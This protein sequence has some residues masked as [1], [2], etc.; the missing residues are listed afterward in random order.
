MAN[1]RVGT[2]PGAG[3]KP[4]S[5]N[6]LTEAK[7]ARL[8]DLA[9]AYTEKALATLAEIMQDED[10]NAAARVSAANSLLD[11]GHG[12]PIQATTEIPATE[13]PVPFDGWHIERAESDPPETD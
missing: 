4:G 1:G 10:A 6:K 13:V 5:K 3:R 11:R 8:S 2:R 12:K 7:K 9:G